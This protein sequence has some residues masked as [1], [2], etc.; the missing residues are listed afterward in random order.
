MF[1]INFIK[2]LHSTIAISA[3]LAVLVGITY[4]P[5]L[6][7]PF[8]SDDYGALRILQQY[9]TWA[10]VQSIFDFSDTIF[11]RPLGRLYFLIIYKMFGDN[12]FYIHFFALIIHTANS[13]LFFIIYNKLNHSRLHAILAACLYA[14][15]FKVHAW[16][17]AWGVGIFDLGGMFFF[18]LAFYFYLQNRI[19]AIVLCYLVGC[20]FKESVIILPLV[21]AAHYALI[22]RKPKNDLAVI[23]L[24]VLIGISSLVILIIK[25]QGISIFSLDEKHPYASS[26]WGEHLIHNLFFYLGVLTSSVIPYVK[27]N[28]YIFYFFSFVFF[29]AVA[30]LVIILNASQEIK[31]RIIFYSLWIIASLLPPLI[32]I[33][34]QYNYYA[35]YA[36]PA[37]I[38]IVLDLINTKKIPILISVISI[39]ILSNMLLAYDLYTTKNVDRNKENSLI[40]K[41]YETK[42]ILHGLAKQLPAINDNTVIVIE[43]AIFN[44]KPESIQFLY[45][46]STV[47]IYNGNGAYL[48]R[49]GDIGYLNYPGE[50]VTISLP[51]TYFFNLKDGI[52]T[53]NIM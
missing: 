41:G 44:I 45:N 31:R 36:L 37:F 7:L 9:D 38:A 5:S 32:M 51:S 42:A 3:T 4:W 2:S 43:G 28:S 11:H 17:L 13:V 1:H 18:L 53:K 12:P 23:K 16:I 40:L 29:I 15:A 24:G 19:G 26:L 8:I 39:T 21:I 34:H 52:L 14:T 10:V 47:Q 22:A 48:V 20:L 25:Y 46:N 30:N 50:S 6:F 35:I 49:S 27:T 33:D